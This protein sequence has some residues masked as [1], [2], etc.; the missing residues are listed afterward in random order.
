MQFSFTRKSCMDNRHYLCI[1]DKGVVGLERW[2]VLMDSSEQMFPQS[3]TMLWPW[4]PEDLDATEDEVWQLAQ[5]RRHRQ[6][7]WLALAVVVGMMLGL[8]G[9]QQFDQVTFR[10]ALRANATWIHGE[11]QHEQ[12]CLRVA[13]T[14]AYRAACAQHAHDAILQQQNAFAT[15]NIPGSMHDQ[16]SQMQDAFA[17]LDAA[18]CWNTASKTAD[19]GCLTQ[20]APRLR[21]LASLDASDAIRNQ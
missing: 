20:F 2:W 8:V 10:S 19:A 16:A 18:T 7:C 21:E 17:A 12:R 13:T 11:I 14:V 15:I 1:N 4:Q 3:A 9:W 6:R 5:T